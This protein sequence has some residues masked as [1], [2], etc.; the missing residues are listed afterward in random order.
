MGQSRT[1]GIRDLILETAGNI[2]MKFGFKKTTM[3]DIA[4]ALHRA[5]SSVYY[6]FNSKEEIYRDIIQKERIEFN[7]ELNKVLEKENKPENRLKIYLTTRL[8]LLRKMMNYYSALM[9]KY[10]ENYPF[11]NEFR[12]KYF[13]D[14]VEGITKILKEG[15]KLGIYS[16]NNFRQ[17]AT[18]I[19]IA[20]K[21]LEE[22]AVIVDKIND[23]EKDMDGLLN[24]ILYGIIKR[25]S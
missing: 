24:L 7:N 10:L 6:Y 16:I 11:I 14:E 25:K 1:S 3:E 8:R 9:D 12:K 23:I 17:T 4:K 18:Q 22:K 19:S 5:K 21:Y 20:L 15:A 2:F 13:S